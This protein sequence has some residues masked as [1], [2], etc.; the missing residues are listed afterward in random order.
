MLK[1]L[2]KAI[3][4]VRHVISVHWVGVKLI[5]LRVFPVSKTTVINL[6]LKLLLKAAITVVVALEG[7]SLSIMLIVVIT[8]L[9]V[10]CL[11]M[12]GCRLYVV[13]VLL[14][15]VHVLSTHRCLVWLH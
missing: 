5:R 13:K 2:Y 7:S 9:S 3:F 15:Q 10:H 1:T 14:T 4:T 11:L 8:I 12:V 6:L